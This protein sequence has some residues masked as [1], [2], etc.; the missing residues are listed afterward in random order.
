M[1]ASS[2][3]V[4]EEHLKH[5]EEQLVTVTIENQN[6]TE[7]LQGY[8]DKESLGK[9]KTEIAIERKRFQILEDKYKKLERDYKNQSVHSEDTDHG[10]VDVSIKSG[11]S[12]SDKPKKNVSKHLNNKAEGMWKRLIQRVYNIMD[13]FAE[14][15]Q[16]VPENDEGPPLTVKQLKENINRFS[17]DFKPYLDTIKGIQQMLAWKVP[18]HTLLMFLVYLISVWHGCLLSVI[19]FCLVFRLTISLLNHIGFT[20][21]FNFFQPLL[22]P[23]DEEE[24]NSGL[25]DKFNIVIQ[26]ARKVQNGLGAAADG[27]EKITSLLTWK[28]PVTGKLY[29]M[30]I[31][32]FAI[33]VY[34]PSI[35][36]YT[37]IMGV[38]FGVKLFIINYL[39]NRFPR[40]KKK[41][42]SS[43][44][45]WQSLPT[46][47]QYEKTC[48]KSEINQYVL[49]DKDKK[50]ENQLITPTKEMKDA[51]KEFCQLFSLP[52]SESPLEV[53]F[54]LRER[55]HHPRRM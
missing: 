38:I 3:E 34:P 50:K 33:S 2:Y 29:L 52:N 36:E 51:D 7:E 22:D 18:S 42:D 37:Y 1:E 21:N 17:A 9:L 43:Y 8:K 39:Y 19:L 5:L 24:T 35:S 48:I 46:A 32:G 12:Q 44:Q 30:L 27:L 31:V 13:D 14:E 54:V 4:Y 55:N 20:V 16:E 47:A 11:K 41:Y 28:T 10:W 45:T 40:L 53:S 15:L 23:K 25:S 6:L 49:S 26:V